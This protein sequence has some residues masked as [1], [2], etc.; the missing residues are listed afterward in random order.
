MTDEFDTLFV[1]I[2][3][4][5]TFEGLGL[6]TRLAQMPLP[7]T[8]NYV[9]FVAGAVYA[10]CTPIG[11]AIG[12]GVRE[13]YNPNSVTANIVSGVLDSISAGI[14]L[15]TGLVELLAHQFLF[16][17]EMRKAPLKVV[18]FGVICTMF[19]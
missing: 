12:L 6:G 13:T 3:F 14:L 1:V 18:A 19:G 9:P 5:Q 15:Y 10:L 7:R 8:L 17:E 2:I 16:N 4:H 11:M